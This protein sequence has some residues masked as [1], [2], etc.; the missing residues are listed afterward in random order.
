MVL[1]QTDLPDPVVPAIRRWG[2]AAK[3]PTIALPEMFLPSAIGNFMS[4]DLK[5]EL[6]KISLK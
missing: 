1:M 2:I 4:F 6:F 3:S 5:S